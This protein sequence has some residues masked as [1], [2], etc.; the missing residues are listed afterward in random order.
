MYF[1]EG[2]IKANRI[3]DSEIDAANPPEGM[4]PL[5]EYRAADDQVAKLEKSERERLKLP[6]RTYGS[7]PDPDARENLGPIIMHA[8]NVVLRREENGTSMI[9]GNTTNFDVSWAPPG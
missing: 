9:T 6:L 7:K 4:Q 1:I 3:T 2:G 5:V 8:Y